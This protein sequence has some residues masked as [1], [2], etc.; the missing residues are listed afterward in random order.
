MTDR[1][2]EPIPELRHLGMASRLYGTILEMRS[3][4]TIKVEDTSL[5]LFQQR[6]WLWSTFESQ[7]QEDNAHCTQA[8][9]VTNPVTA[10]HDTSAAANTE[11]ARA[12]GIKTT[13]RPEILSSAW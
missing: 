10:V 6:R 13:A 9:S 11:D 3:R 7:C 2:W 8:A 5:A 1:E 12:P 4:G